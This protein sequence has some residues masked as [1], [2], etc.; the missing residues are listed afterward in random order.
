MAAWPAWAR[1]RPSASASAS[2]AR[3]RRM[4]SPSAAGPGSRRRSPGAAPARC[5]RQPAQQRQ[6]PLRSSSS[7]SSL[8]ITTRWGMPS[9]TVLVTITSSTLA[10]RK[11]CA[12]ASGTGLSRSARSACPW[13]RPAHPG[14]GRHQAATVAEAR[15]PPRSARAPRRRTGRPAARW[16]RCRCG[17]RPRALHDDDVGAQLLGLHGVLDGAAGGHAHDAGASL[18]AGS[19]RARRAVVAGGAH[20]LAR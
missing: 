1:W 6:R 4:A 19:A 13:R 12:V 17:R 11:R 20:A 7:T 2:A 18:S 15:R 16:A 3:W 14:Q 8:R 5:G 9:S 10:A